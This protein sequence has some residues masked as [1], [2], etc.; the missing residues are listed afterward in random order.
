MNESAPKYAIILAGG[1]GERMHSSDLHK[2]CFPIDGRPAISRAI[3][4][5]RGCGIRQ[6]VVVV[7]DKAEQV[8]NTIGSRY[9]GVI[10]AYQSE[11]KGTADA[12]KTGIKILESLG[13]DEE[14]L[15]VAGDKFIE[16]S[17]LK[18]LFA[19][20]YSNNCSCAFIMGRI[21]EESGSGRIVTQED[22]SILGNMETPDIKQKK[23]LWEI[24]AQA[25]SQKSLDSISIR[26]MIS[27]E[28]R[29]EKAVKAFGRIWQVINEKKVISQMEIFDLI[30]PDA[31]RFLFLDKAGEW[32]T[33]TPQQANAINLVNLSVY[34]TKVKALEYVF[35]KLN[36]KNAQQEEYLSDIIT[37]L[38]RAPGG[39][40]V[41]VRALELTDAN[42]VMGFNNPEELLRIE[43]YVREKKQ[44]RIR[45]FSLP[46]TMF[47]TVL[48]WKSVFSAIYHDR[49][50][51][52]NVRS[53]LI[54]IYG[55]DPERVRDHAGQ[56]LSALEFAFQIFNEDDNVIITRSPGHLNVQSRHIDH[57]GG[58]CN[59]MSIDYETWMVARPREDDRINLWNVD[60]DRFPNRSFS[61]GELIR[62]LPWEDW[63]ALVNSEVVAKMALAAG[64]DW[65]QYIKAAAVRLQKK[66]TSVRLH[67]ADIVVGGNIP[68]AAGLGSSSS[69]VV[70]AAETLVT[71]NRLE[72]FPS[73]F[74]DLC[75]E[76]EWFVGMRGAGADHA[77]V[78]Y[79][80][81]GKIVKVK[82]F[83]FAVDEIIPFPEEYGYVICDS[84]V[85]AKK[86]INAMDQFNHRIACY[87]LG[88][89]IIKRLFPHYRPLLH[90]LRDVNTQTLG[91]PLSSIYKIILR[92]PENATRDQLEELLPQENLN[93][94]FGTHKSPDDGLYPIRGVVLFG[95]AECER[96]RLYTRALKDND[97]ESIGRMMNVSHNGDRVV[98]LSESDALMPYIAPTSNSYLLDLI[99]DLECQEPERVIRA[100]LQW[101]PGSYRCSIPEIDRMVDIA[102]RVKGVIGAQLAG[103]G[104]G[105]CMMVLVHRDYAGELKEYLLNQYYDPEGVSP[106]VLFCTPVA[107]SGV[108]MQE[109]NH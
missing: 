87:H 100:Q 62:E 4:T 18:Q 48:E 55:N 17:A 108:L 34:I 12:A 29:E 96:S 106:S 43:E 60:S 33:V 28:F 109:N 66:F 47:R 64:G 22:G 44:G 11:Q 15:L 3:D 51:A 35:S 13:L 78:K 90:H 27:A 81:T 102:V 46:D 84:G 5:Y 68:I 86:T 6:F 98:Q 40:N 53:H 107:G 82:F 97:I 2:V 95:L 73:Q 103:A 70:A 76:G 16:Q 37:I 65:S 69:L 92:L 32:V 89:R 101:Q 19:L 72:T 1:K 93:P 75:G 20:Y 49:G 45:D 59:L 31:T 39:E 30:P 63:L 83:D 21:S 26:K 52:D 50:E 36:R 104:L 38:A 23:I 25:E 10:F 77:A 7:G 24:R 105:G 61:I 71:L 79:G 8:M 14:V 94:V 54:S 42:H 57:Q 56:C 99:D 74:V 85:Q 41:A 9:D 91:V 88:L 67:G 80:Q 58:H